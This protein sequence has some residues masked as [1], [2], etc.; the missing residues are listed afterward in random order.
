ETDGYAKWD[1]AQRLVLNCMNECFNV[2]EDKWQISA[3]LIAALRHVLLDDSLDADLR[4]ELLTPPGFEE[5]ATLLE[6]VDVSKVEAVRDYFRIQLGTHLYAEI[7]ALYQ[8]LW[9]AEDH[10]MNGLAYG[11]R[12]LRNVCLW[13]IM[14]VNEAAAIDACQQQFVHAKTM[15]DQIASFA[16][17]VNC[18]NQKMREQAV[19]D[20]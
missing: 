5:V 4:A 3:A 12:R 8:Q 6:V 19:N 16:L 13:L 2:P 17:L 11:R 15:T 18:S 10:S 9:Q 20:F 14:K 1:A 7:H